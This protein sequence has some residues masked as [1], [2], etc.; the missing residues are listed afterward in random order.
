M[1]TSIKPFPKKWLCPRGATLRGLIFENST[2]RIPLTLFHDLTVPLE[3][4]VDRGQTVATE[5]CLNFIQFGVRR[6]ADLQNRTFRFPNN[7]EEGYVDGGVYLRNVHSP[8]DVPRI[9]FGAW[10]PSATTRVTIELR[11]AFEFEATGFKDMR[12]QI[13]CPLR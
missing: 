4:F 9:T 3:P 11:I 5:L 1:S 8:I 6:L 2:A 7:P 13:E 12:A 10:S